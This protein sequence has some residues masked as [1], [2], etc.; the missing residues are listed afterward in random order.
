MKVIKVG[1]INWKGAL[2]A[3]SVGAYY[4]LATIWYKNIEMTDDNMKRETGY[5]TSVHTRQKRELINAEYLSHKQIG[6][7]KYSYTVGENV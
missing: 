3:L 4:L 6:K 5:G 2:D 1:K 7:G